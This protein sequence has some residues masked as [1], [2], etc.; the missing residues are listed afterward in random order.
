MLVV[1]DAAEVLPFITMTISK[2]GLKVQGAGDSAEGLECYH[3]LRPELCLVISDIL[4]PHMNGLE[5]ARAI[6]RID[7]DTPIL[8]MS[9]SKG[10][11]RSSANRF[12]WQ[13]LMR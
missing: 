12:S 6:R 8:L 13:D 5:L 9:G 4:M 1:N 2:S 10:R 11:F 7:A 3:K